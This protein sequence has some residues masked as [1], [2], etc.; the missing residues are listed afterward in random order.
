[1]GQQVLAGDAGLA[2]GL[3]V[4]DPELL[5]LHAVVATRL[6]LPAKLDAVLALLLAPA[7]MLAG[8]VGA[9]LDATLV[10]QAALALEEQLL[11]LTAA[12]LAL[13]GGIAGHGSNPPALA[14]TAAVV[15]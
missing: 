15:G 1:H 3:V 8:R 5:L 14:G 2:A 10:G 9:P 12:L 13:G 11:A 6:L 4:V 7:A